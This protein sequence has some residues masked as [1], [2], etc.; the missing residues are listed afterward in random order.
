MI[1][2]AK[3][4]K[5]YNSTIILDNITVNIPKNKKVVI[6]GINGCGK[7]TLINIISKV[8]INYDGKILNNT[9]IFTCFSDDYLPKYSTLMNLVKFY[10]LD[11]HETKRYIKK[12][13][14]EY[15]NKIYKH[16][17]FGNKQK[18]KLIFTLLHKCKTLIFDEPTNGLDIV[19]IKNFIEIVNNDTRGFIIVSHD[20]HLISKITT[21]L[22][23][24][25]EKKLV[26][27]E[28]GKD[29]IKYLT[30]VISYE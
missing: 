21:D 5:S 18:F 10:N 7:S 3:L 15:P 22:Y 20:F 28:Y 30:K 24:L 6:V 25:K 11:I 19:T 8:D 17:S 14:F 4:K 9:D 26:K 12:L 29:I 1:K 13:N 2:I 16:L 27:H 23:L